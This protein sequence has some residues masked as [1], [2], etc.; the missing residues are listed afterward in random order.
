MNVKHVHKYT[1]LPCRTFEKI[2]LHDVF[3]L[4]DLAVCR[5]YYGLRAIRKLTLRIPEEP[6]NEARGGKKYRR[7]PDYTENGKN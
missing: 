2:V 1:Y 4:Y 3:Y 5:R 6:G 7:R